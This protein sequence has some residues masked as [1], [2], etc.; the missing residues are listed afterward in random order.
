MALPPVRLRQVRQPGLASLCGLLK[1]GADVRL[2]LHD[3]LQDAGH[4]ER[5][6][7]FRAEDWH[8]KGRFAMDVILGRG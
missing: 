4:A 1:P 2:I 7:H 3:A 8:P 6:E 5:A